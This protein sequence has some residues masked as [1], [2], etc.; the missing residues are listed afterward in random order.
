M[1]WPIDIIR[2]IDMERFS[3]IFGVNPRSVRE[4]LFSRL[5][6][7]AQQRRIGI[8]AHNKNTDRIRA[9]YDR[10]LSDAGKM[11]RELASELL[12]N[13]LYTQRE[14]LSDTLNHLGVKHDH[15]LTEQEVDFF[16]QLEPDKVREL[17]TLLIPTHGK[18]KVGIY[19]RYMKVPGVLE[20][21]AGDAPAT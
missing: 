11:E 17:C 12:R 2:D 20:I 5:G 18:E 9:L 19:L 21:L 10:L 8:R 7:K 1:E 3:E 13:W 6:I 14:L 4:A 16:E 15:G